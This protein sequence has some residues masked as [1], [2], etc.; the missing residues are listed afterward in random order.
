MADFTSAID[1]YWRNGTTWGF[2]TTYGEAGNDKGVAYP[3]N[4]GDTAVC[5]HTIIYNF[6]ETNALGNVVINNRFQLFVSSN[7]V[8]TIGGNLIINGQFEFGDINE[9]TDESDVGTILFD[10]TED[11]K[12]GIIIQNGGKLIVSGDDTYFGYTQKSSLLYDYTGGNQIYLSDTDFTQYIGQELLV[13]KNALYSDYTTDC[14]LCTISDFT[15]LETYTIV[16]LDSTL[17]GIFNSGGIVQNVSRNAIIGKKNSDTSLGEYNTNRPFI[18][19]ESTATEPIQLYNC[20]LHGI[21]G[22][23]GDD[24]IP[25]IFQNSIIRNSCMGMFGGYSDLTLSGLI[26]SCEY[27]IWHVKNSTIDIDFASIKTGA[28][29]TGCA[30]CTILGD[31]VAIGGRAAHGSNNCTF[32]GD[33]YSCKVAAGSM[34][35]GG[36]FI[37]NIY[38]CTLAAEGSDHTFLDGKIGFDASNISKPNDYDFAFTNSPNILVI[39]TKLQNNLSF[40]DKDHDRLNGRIKFSDYRQ[41]KGEHRIIDAFGDIFKV[42]ADESYDRPAQRSFG[43]EYLIEVITSKYISSSNPLEIFR[44]KIWAIGGI[45]KIYKYYVQSTVAIN[46]SDFKLYCEYYDETIGCHKTTLDTS[47]SINERA[48]Q[49]DWSNFIDITINPSQDG[50]ISLYLFIEKYY[51]QD[52]IWIDPKVNVQQL[53]VTPYQH[54]GDSLIHT[55]NHLYPIIGGHHIIRGKF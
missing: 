8:L 42:P 14:C 35:Q 39:N 5:D 33:I 7:S 9:Y 30:G 38:N 47:K 45:E 13:H 40:I 6:A 46:S 19:N 2:D 18:R 43:N 36:I 21:Y 51:E 10:C 31:I 26:F 48:N 53:I 1:G 16:E 11:N 52:K 3:G 29:S 55:S 12:N 24:P 15:S 41:T 49:S 54:D 27:G 17:D 32:L 28:I 4:V 37:N 25:N 44:H 50:Q 22:L 23:I 20:A 34:N